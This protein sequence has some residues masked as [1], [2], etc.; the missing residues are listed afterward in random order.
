VSDKMDEFAVE[1]KDVAKLSTTE[2]R[3]TLGDHVEYRLGIGRRSA[4]DAQHFA[5]RG[6]MFERFG[7]FTGETI[8]LLMGGSSRGTST[9]GG[10]YG[11]VG[12]H[13]LTALPLVLPRRFMDLPS[14]AKRSHGSAA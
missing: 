2:P 3:S 14:W 4:D 12:L 5:R 11:V 7:K 10:P 8:A 6:L 9:G 1:A 13:V